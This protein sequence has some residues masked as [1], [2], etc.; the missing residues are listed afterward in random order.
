MTNTEAVGEN[1]VLKHEENMRRT[2]HVFSHDL[3]NPLLN[4]QALV[5]EAGSLMQEAKDAE[6]AGNDNNLTV[7]LEKELPEVLEMLNKSASIM[8]NMV[9]GANEIY[10]CLFD[11]LECEEVDMHAMF[12][13]CFAQLKLADDSLELECVDLPKVY[14][15]PLT[16]KRVVWEVLCNA[17]KAIDAQQIPSS[18]IIKVSAKQV[19]DYNL[20]AVEDSGCGL[21]ESEMNKAF[22]AFFSGKTFQGSTGLGLTRASA[23]VERHGGKMDIASQGETGA[24]VTFSLPRSA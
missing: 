24:V 17:K 4:I 5:E 13:R 1:V 22:E 14:A 9:L 11:E 19:G 23:W 2:L 21:P 7:I 8:D 20:F 3:R 6:Y 12:F 16:V 15:D 18:Q 10:H